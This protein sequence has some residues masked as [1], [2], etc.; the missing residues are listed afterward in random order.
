[1]IQNTVFKVQCL[2]TQRG[3][4]NFPFL[5][6]KNS[7][8]GVQGIRQSILSMTKVKNIVLNI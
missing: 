5:G 3:P 1:M 7:G 2:P 8:T 6:I 4:D